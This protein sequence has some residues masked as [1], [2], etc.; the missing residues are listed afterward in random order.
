M[1]A[2]WISLVLGFVPG[3]A[4]ILAQPLVDSDT[5]KPSTAPAV[6]NLAIPSLRSLISFDQ[7]LNYRARGCPGS[8]S[9]HTGDYWYRWKHDQSPFRMAEEFHD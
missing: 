8:P 2:L 6:P 4:G 5:N 9:K 1:R 3:S 7:S